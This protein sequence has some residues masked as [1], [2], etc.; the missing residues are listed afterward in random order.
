[1]TKQKWEEKFDKEFSTPRVASH[2]SDL[3]QWVNA[4]VLD[5]KQFISK[6]LQEQ[7]DYLRKC[8]KDVSIEDSK[9]ET[10]IT[11]EEIKLARQE[12]RE[13]IKKEND[14]KKKGLLDIISGWKIIK[15][16]TYLP[17]DVIIVSDK[18]AE[19]LIKYL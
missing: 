3:Q 5:V 19:K 15:S 1:M 11:E 9:L 12:E 4:W 16:S 6:Q 10:K 14:S 17:D 7:K 18:T 13:K 8:Y 2:K